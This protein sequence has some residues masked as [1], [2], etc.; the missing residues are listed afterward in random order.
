MPK[1]TILKIELS[2]SCACATSNASS[3]AIPE[4]ATVCFMWNC[5]KVES[6]NTEI[7]HFWSY[8]HEAKM[9]FKRF[10][11]QIR[12]FSISNGTPFTLSDAVCDSNS[13]WCTIYF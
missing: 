4:D 2:V 8:V 10:L 5:S 7:V 3:V 11:I 1:T 9:C 12:H 13:H 6:C